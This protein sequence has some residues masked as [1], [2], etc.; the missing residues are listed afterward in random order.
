V[1][2]LHQSAPLAALVV[3]AAQMGRRRA[4][5]HSV[6]KVSTVDPERQPQT[7]AAAVAV[8]VRRATQTEPPKVATAQTSQHSSDS[9]QAR[10]S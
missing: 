1:V 8:V 7:A 5:L 10:H 2:V 6:V 3:V 4:A 9:R